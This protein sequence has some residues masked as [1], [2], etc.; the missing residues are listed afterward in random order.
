MA[1]VG[2]AWLLPAGN[3]KV[4]IKLRDLPRAQLPEK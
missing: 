4:E 1:S 2:L 3:D